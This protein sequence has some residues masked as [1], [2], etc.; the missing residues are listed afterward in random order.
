MPDGHFCP[1]LTTPTERANL[2]SVTTPLARPR[3]T[4]VPTE[5]RPAA[6][7]PTAAGFLVEVTSDEFQASVEARRA[8]S[9]PQESREIARR[10]RHE[11]AERAAAALRS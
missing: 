3:Q 7:D 8:A 1:L 10:Y 11:R 4:S 5:A 9:S 6:A 2:T